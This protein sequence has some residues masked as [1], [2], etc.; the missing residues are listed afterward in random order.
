[1]TPQTWADLLLMALVML[2]QIV[3]FGFLISTMTEIVTNSMTSLRQ[4]EKYKDKMENV[5][6]WLMQYDIPA[7]LVDEVKVYAIFAATLSEQNAPV[8]LLQHLDAKT[9]RGRELDPQR[10]SI[11]SPIRCRLLHDR[12]RLVSSLGGIESCL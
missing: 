1:V 8:L 11:H 5:S 9:I 6:E 3:I 7:H 10:S 4:A 2:T 12:T